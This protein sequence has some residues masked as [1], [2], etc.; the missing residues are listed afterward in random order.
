MKESHRA[1]AQHPCLVRSLP[2]IASVS[3]PCAMSG[4]DEPKL[5]REE[6]SIEELTPI[7]RK[8]CVGTKGY[9]ETGGD[10][11]IIKDVTNEIAW[12]VRAA[13]FTP[14][15]RLEIHHQSTS[16]PPPPPGRHA[17]PPP[18]SAAPPPPRRG[19]AALLRGNVR[20]GDPSN[21]LVPP[22]HHCRT[23]TKTSRSRPRHCPRRAC[24][25]RPAPT[26]EY[27]PLS[28]VRHR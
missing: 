21:R 6:M 2:L 3:S 12:N 22:S 8:L 10:G 5:L 27:P 7:A 15:P 24:R 23:Q 4:G 1:C 14:Q 19:I 28:A 16:S 20:H 17:V 18:P 11:P 25:P 26:A 13:I 9:P